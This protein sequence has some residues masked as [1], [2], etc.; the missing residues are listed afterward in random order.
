MKKKKIKTIENEII[1][2]DE[3]YDFIKVNKNNI[4]NLIRNKESLEK[5]NEIVINV[6]KIVIHAYQFIKLYCIDLYNNNYVFP[7]INKEF[8]MDVFKVITIRKDNRGNYKDV[9]APDQLL[10]LKIFFENHYKQTMNNDILCYDKLS[11]ILA[12]EAIDMETNISVNIHEHFIQHVNKFINITFDFKEKHKEITKSKETIDDKKKIQQKLNKEFKDIQ[13]DLLSFNDVLTSNVKYHQWIKQQRK[14]IWRNK[15][16]FDKDNLAYDLK[17]NNSFY[18][19]SLFYI[20]HELEKIF[21][22]QT[23]ENEIRLNNKENLHKQI[24]LFNVLP[25]RTNIIPKHI[26]F[27]TPAIIQTLINENSGKYLKEYKKNNLQYD[28]WNKI[29]KL[30]KRTFKKDKTKYQFNYMIK[31]DGVSISVLFIRMKPDG[32]PMFKA[33]KQCKGDND[34][35]YIEKLEFT[36]EI[37]KKKIVCIDP[38][39]SDLIYC[40]SKDKDGKLETFRYTQNQRRIETGKKKYMKIIDFNKKHEIIN[41]KTIK[42]IESELCKFNRKTVSYDKFL[43]YIKEKNR[44]NSILFNHYVKEYYRKFK[45]HNYTNTQKSESKMI[46][47]FET[48]FGEPKDVIIAIGDY[49]KNEQLKGTEPSICKRFRRIFTNAQYPLYLINEFRTSKLCNECHEELNKFMER[50][51]HKPKHNSK[52]I[53]VHGLLR[54]K[55]GNCKLIHNR[56]KNA[57]ENMLYIIDY[58]KENKERPK[59]YRRNCHES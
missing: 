8:I 21:D 42:Q 45:L 13:T 1:N 38:G 36:E 17:S 54:H 55:D 57:V 47:N 37:N 4:K 48:K 3:K 7:K 40:G 52:I 49:D 16:C 30:N 33:N 19:K 34:Y 35:Q 18:V 11:Y 9:D 2:S 44:I 32:K 27:D 25:L 28:L 51:S 58:V 6:N 10:D 50:K 31:T 53:L 14:K 56:D 29:F 23:K 43:E 20:E 15:T 5:I 59:E 46:K 24:E 12:Y 22:K 39:M 41:N 26:C